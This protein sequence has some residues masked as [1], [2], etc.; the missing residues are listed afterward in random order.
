MM[1]NKTKRTRVE[2]VYIDDVVV[3]DLVR[4]LAVCAVAVVD[5][6]FILY[7]GLSGLVVGYIVS[8]LTILLLLL[9][10]GSLSFRNPE[11]FL[12]MS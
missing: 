1:R 5:D 10:V 11:R 3:L 7:L 8:H 2:R 9:F 6:A 12:T 4:V